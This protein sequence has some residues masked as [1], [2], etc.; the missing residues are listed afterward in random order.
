VGGSKAGSNG[1]EIS[2]ED[3]SLTQRDPELLH[4][5]A[6]G[7]PRKR[8]VDADDVAARTVGDGLEEIPAG[9]VDLGERDEGA[10]QVV[11]AARPELQ[12]REVRR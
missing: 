1:P 9:A 2:V 11:T 10:P 4:F 8:G 5:V 12:Q 6:E 3:E 7:R